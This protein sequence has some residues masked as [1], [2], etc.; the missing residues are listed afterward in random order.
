VTAASSYTDRAAKEKDG[1]AMLMP[2]LNTYVTIVSD[3]G[4]KWVSNR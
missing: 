2:A 1:T 3:K 4:K